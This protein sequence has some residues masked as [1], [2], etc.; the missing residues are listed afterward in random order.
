MKPSR[1]LLALV[2]LSVLTVSGTASAVSDC[3]PKEYYGVLLR[4]VG[5][6]YNSNSLTFAVQNSVGGLNSGAQ[7]R[8]SFD[9]AESDKAKASL[10][11]ALTAEMS[12]APVEITCGKGPTGDAT[13]AIG[14]YLY[15]E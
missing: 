8:L 13:G 4:Y 3:P 15:N 7:Y 6:D 1:H 2:V 9:G 14:I 12:G 10:A 11:V 5:Y